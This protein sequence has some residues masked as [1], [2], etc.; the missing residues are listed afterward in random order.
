MKLLHLGEL[1]IP[2]AVPPAAPAADAPDGPPAEPP[3]ANIP[4]T[5]FLRLKQGIVAAGVIAP[6]MSDV[7][8]DQG[9]PVYSTRS[10]L[11]VSE[12]DQADFEFLFQAISA[13]MGM[14][15]GDAV[16]VEAFRQDPQREDRPGVS[17]TVSSL[18]E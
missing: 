7:R 15:T 6:P 14:T 4:A 12:L 11:H 10:Y 18:A 1:L 8:N 5:E 16:A 3:A 13:K 9:E 2:S 17:G